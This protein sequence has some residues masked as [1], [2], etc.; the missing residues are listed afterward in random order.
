MISDFS[1]KI[2]SS[3]F[4]YSTTAYYKAILSQ[5][6]NFAHYIDIYKETISLGSIQTQIDIQPD[7]LGANA[8]RVMAKH[9]KPDFIFNEND[10]S[11]FVY[12]WKFNGMK[13]RCEVHLYKQKAFMVNYIYNQL[14]KSE[15]EYVMG[16]IC[17]KYLD[18]Y[19]NEID[20]AGTKIS[21]RNHN[22]LF[23]GDYMLGLKV[24]YMSNCESDW[25]EG[26]MA[27]VNMKTARNEAR[28]RIGEKRFYKSI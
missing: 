25:F 22:V 28:I 10:L 6:V 13:T 5:Y 21:D 14:D 7:I 12:K 16:T 15:R 18:K 19:V 27:E 20:F 26:M 1:K 3:N 2:F 11:V 9:G 24:T 17:N 8:R 4:Y 23:V